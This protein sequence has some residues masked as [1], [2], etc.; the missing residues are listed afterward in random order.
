M[1]A[2]D[3]VV[4]LFNGV[5]FLGTVYCLRNLAGAV[6]LWWRVRRK[7]ANGAFRVLSTHG[8]GVQVLILTGNAGL[9]VLGIPSLLAI[10]GPETPRSTR[11][12]PPV[13][14]LTVVDLVITGVSYLTHRERTQ[15][16]QA[17]GPTTEEVY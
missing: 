11:A 3:G 8:L 13:V 4:L 2:L 5:G 14:A 15:M 16:L 12:I 17:V 6:Q 10:G 9:A 1:T 7:V